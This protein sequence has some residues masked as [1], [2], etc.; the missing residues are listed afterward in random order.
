MAVKKSPVREQLERLFDQ[1]ILVLDGAMGTMLQA[2]KLTREDYH[3]GEFADSPHELKGNGDMLSLTRPDI[4][5]KIHNSYLAA[6]SDIIETN[7]FS[8]TVVAQADYGFFHPA[9]Q[10]K[11]S[12]AKLA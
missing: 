2:E 11:I 4:V 10:L 8:A 9:D 7:T 5:S 3:R 1:R 12:K 6:G